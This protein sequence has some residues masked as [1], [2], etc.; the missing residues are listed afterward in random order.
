MSANAKPDCIPSL[1]LDGVR[2]IG[3]WTLFATVAKLFVIDL[4][5]DQL[6]DVA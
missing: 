2:K 6:S 3:L 1:K 5:E 4:A